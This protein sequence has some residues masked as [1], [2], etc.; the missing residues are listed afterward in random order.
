MP[1]K[2]SRGGRGASSAGT[3][4]RKK[5]ADALYDMAEPFVR[6]TILTDLC[7]HPWIMGDAIGQGGFGC[8]YECAS[9]RTKSND[10]CYVVKVEPDS[11][12]PL[13]CEMHF[14]LQLGKKTLQDTYVR[15]NRL[16]HLGVPQLISHGMYVSPLTQRRYRFL[17][18]QRF[19]Q[20]LSQEWELNNKQLSEKRVQIVCKQ[21]LDVLEYIHS[22]SYVH[23]DIKAEN[24]LMNKQSTNFIYL[25]DYG[26]SRKVTLTYEEK[27]QRRHEGTLEYTSIDVHRGAHPTFRGDIEILFYNMLHWLGAKLPWLNI[28]DGNRVQQAKIQA[29]SDPSGFVST[30]FDQTNMNKSN[31][32]RQQQQKV[33]SKFIEILIQFYRELIQMEYTDKANYNRFREII[34][35]NYRRRSLSASERLTPSKKSQLTTVNDDDDEEEEEEDVLPVQYSSKKKHMPR[36]LTSPSPTIKKRM[37]TNASGIP[38]S[39]N[40]TRT[41]PR[42]RSSSR[43]K[44]SS[45]SNRQRSPSPVIISSRTPVLDKVAKGSGISRLQ[46]RQKPLFL[47]D[48]NDED[49]DID[50]LTVMNPKLSSTR[51]ERP[52]NQKRLLQ[53]STPSATSIRNIADNESS[54]SITKPI[55]DIKPLIKPLQMNRPNINDRTYVLDKEE[56]A[57]RSNLQNGQRLIRP[58]IQTVTTNS[59]GKYSDIVEKVLAGVPLEP[60]DYKKVIR[61]RNK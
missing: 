36:L 17:I 51:I 22:H 56:M 20:T 52:M 44:R 60:E 19:H 40:P 30:L 37:K 29:R 25:I 35:G 10:Y 49:D 58:N 1:P 48:E 15:A 53:K 55:R 3:G 43:E 61:P 54:P 34:S 41:T 11:N 5:K 23:A 46:Q 38:I 39:S 45:Y 6:G 7:Q 13:F 12:G 31:T 28:Q 16:D 2:G 50:L 9:Q 21:L 42:A 4:G 18:I 26:L 33:T 57:V 59:P 8:I 32:N 27:P 24:I 14:Y 47:D